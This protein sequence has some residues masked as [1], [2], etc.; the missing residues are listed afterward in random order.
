M[1]A[2]VIQTKS[3]YLDLVSVFFSGTLKTFPRVSIM[4]FSLFNIN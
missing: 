1:S 2:K 3:N 4:N